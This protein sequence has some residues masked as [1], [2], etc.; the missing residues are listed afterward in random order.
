MAKKK[1]I[2]PDNKDSTIA[3]KPLQTT[4]DFDDVPRGPIFEISWVHEV[5][6]LGK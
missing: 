6:K 4:L 3:V 1:Q 5:K 2:E